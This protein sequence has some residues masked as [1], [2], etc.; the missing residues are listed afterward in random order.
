MRPRHQLGLPHV[1]HLPAVLLPVD[2][3]LAAPLPA[4]PLPVV[5]RRAAAAVVMVAEVVAEV[6][7]V[8]DAAAEVVQ[9]A[10]P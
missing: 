8:G 4:A 10:G 7:V 3:H 6:A 9:Q 2:R 5:L 1:A